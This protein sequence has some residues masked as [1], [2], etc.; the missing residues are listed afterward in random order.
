MRRD[1][2]NYH[3]CNKKGYHTLNTFHE[4][5]VEKCFQFAYSMTYGQSGEHRNHRS[6]GSHQ[7]KNG[8]LFINTFQGKLAEF[9]TYRTLE[10]NNILCDPPDLDTYSLGAWD[11]SD[12]IVN[13]KHINIK[14]SKYFANLMLLET[15]DWD[16]SGNYIPNL[17]KGEV[18]KYD[19]FVFVRI[20]PDGEKIM[21]NNKL[22]YSSN[23]EKNKL[24]EIV[25]SETWECDI[26]GYITNIELCAVISS[27]QLIPKG[28]KLNGGTSMDA[29]NYYVQSGA[30]HDFSELISKLGG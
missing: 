30:L 20:K 19:Y 5:T 10:R 3:I 22:L 12:L 14:S 4:K 7:R 16:S 2:N 23:T 21:K 15:K 26:P 1:G 25:S 11:D 27:K 29:E 8:E 13:G 24:W 6:G 9:A 28:A 18:A 17:S